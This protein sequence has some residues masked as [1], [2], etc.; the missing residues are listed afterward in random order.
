MLS[1]SFTI[2]CLVHMIVWLFVIFGGFISYKCTK[3]IMLGIIPLIYVLHIMPFHI[4]LKKKFKQIHDDID[5]QIELFDKTEIENISHRDLLMCKDAYSSLP[6]NLSKD[7]QDLIIKI[8]ILQEN[9]Y[10]VPKIYRYIRRN[11]VDCFGDPLSPQGMLIL[12]YIINTYLL[13]F[14]WK[15]ID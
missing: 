3:I 4:F 13:Y 10:I 8:Y 9:K 2:L 12:G 11:F 5:T 14:Y 1:I 15:K 6:S 7:K